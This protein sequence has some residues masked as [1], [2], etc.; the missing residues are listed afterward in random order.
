MFRKKSQRSSTKRKQREVNFKRKSIALSNYLQQTF[1]SLTIESETIPKE[2]LD[3]IIT[4][5]NFKDLV[6]FSLV[7]RAAYHYIHNEQTDLWKNYLSMIEL[8]SIPDNEKL[9]SKH[10]RLTERDFY[11]I[12]SE[13]LTEEKK[14]NPLRI[15]HNMINK[16]DPTLQIIYNPKLYKLQFRLI[17]SA[18]QPLYSQLISSN[19]QFGNTVFIKNF[20]NPI[21]QSILLNNF[22]KFSKFQLYQVDSRDFNLNLQN[23]QSVVEFFENACLR[24]IEIGYDNQDFNTKVS[25]YT[26]ILLNLNDNLINNNL[27][28]FFLQ[29]LNLNELI[30][31]N[32]DTY[33]IL[34]E[35]AEGK[36]DQIYKIDTLSL[37]NYFG[38]LTQLLN[39]QIEI[40]DQI[41]S[42][43]QIQLILKIFEEIIQNYILEFVGLLSQKAKNLNIVNESV[44][45]NSGNDK[46]EFATSEFN[47]SITLL[48]LVYSNL[49][50]LISNKIKDSKN[51]GKYFKPNLVNLLN[52]YME[53]LI[54]EYLADESDFF[55]KITEFNIQ[56]WDEKT[57]L[58]E[59]QIEQEILKNVKATNDVNNKNSSFLKIDLVTGF[60]N[61]L[62]PIN[63][64]FEG[65]MGSH[66]H[67]HDDNKEH[68]EN[69]VEIDQHQPAPEDDNMM[70][71]FEAK[72]AIMN[73]KLIRIKSFF[74]LDLSLNILNNARTSIQRITVFINEINKL[75]EEVES[76]LDLDYNKNILRSCK[77]QIEV[78]FIK[79]TEILGE[80]HV[81]K[82]FEK[83]I[84]R[85]KD[86]NPDDNTNGT[87][88]ETNNQNSQDSVQPL[89]MFTE[90]VNIGDLIQNLIEVFYT[91]ELVNKKIINKNQDFLSKVLQSKKK[92]ELMLDDSVADG[93]NIGIDA[94]INKI[95]YIYH[96]FQN[97]KDFI[98]DDAD[99]HVKIGVV[100]VCAMKTIDLLSTHVNLLIG[101]TEKSTIDVFQ[102]EVSQRFFGLIVKN[103]KTLKINTTGALTLISDL[104]Y[105]YDFIVTLRQKQILP[106]FIGLKTV[107]QIYLIDGSDAKLIGKTISD[108]NRFNGIFQ[109]EEI[110]EL[111][112]CRADWLKVK[113]E[114]EK[115]MF[116][117]LECIIV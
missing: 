40:I 30:V 45:F 57:K 116:G 38:N 71:E 105:Y 46:K 100:T 89:V 18:L 92:F 1:N 61:I 42:D 37:N 21:H 96:N 86:Y 17:Y 67:S 65:M 8:F 70:T 11:Q 117:M 104:N 31:D 98:P 34:D 22:M 73:N 7:N 15:Y 27:V 49:I 41:F 23:L 91:E 78:I 102:Q 62:K 59:N 58:E 16:D 64:T 109:Q 97:P 6:N 115:E 51:G 52:L 76:I 60:K 5:L 39:S 55:E 10:L 93:L 20:N 54:N 14:L 111:V 88:S 112:Q 12:N 110:Y 103:L 47:L 48:P 107:G 106:Y 24:E 43:D 56:N 29:K 35:Y 3:N 79:I 32:V 36:E 113:R 72:L 26:N 9:K 63:V 87:A 82:G 28:N 77:K 33:F 84:K 75:N 114:V 94:L 101:V 108:L 19:L 53:N 2:I 66:S 99:K 50:N 83:A 69:A 44:I 95:Q 85:L 74:S 68:D 90:L 13:V 4:Y 80:Q 25:Y 81:K